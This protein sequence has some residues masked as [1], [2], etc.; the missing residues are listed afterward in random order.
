MSKVQQPT[1]VNAK[2]LGFYSRLI[3]PVFPSNLILHIITQSLSVC[4]SAGKFKAQPA[5][6]A[7]SLLD[8]NEI[9][10]LDITLTL[11]YPYN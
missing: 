4:S 11:Q 9:P 2:E 8:H 6:P 10:R 3:S 1:S 5:G 7:S